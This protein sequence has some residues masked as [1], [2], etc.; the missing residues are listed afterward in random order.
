MK[1]PLLYLGIALVFFGGF[2]WGGAFQKD[3]DA[4]Q[5]AALKVV[6]EALDSRL[7]ECEGASGDYG[8]IPDTTFTSPEIAP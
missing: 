5:I 6:A 8:L 1:E 2:L 3:R 4:A 7:K